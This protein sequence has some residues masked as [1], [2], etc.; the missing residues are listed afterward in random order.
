MANGAVPAGAAPPLLPFHRAEGWGRSTGVTEA[1]ST[2]R[3]RQKTE[4]G[5]DDDEQLETPKLMTTGTGDDF[6][7]RTTKDGEDVPGNRGW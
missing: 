1:D 6:F 3:T 2:P 5:E 4:D 7:P